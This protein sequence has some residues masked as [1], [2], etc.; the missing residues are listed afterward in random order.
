M[1]TSSRRSRGGVRW[2]EPGRR[3]R[4]RPSLLPVAVLLAVLAAAGAVGYLV[5]ERSNDKAELRET[6]VRFAA[7]WERGDTRAMYREL[8]ADARATYTAR[9]FAADYRTA[10][11][12][13]TAE[14]V[15]VGRIREAADGRV[16]LQVAVRTKLFGTLRGRIALPVT[17]VGE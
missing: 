16:P 3:R 7:A 6:A 17:R 15:A 11:R 4:R 14:K 13:A 5:H 2:L 8:D 9:R 10:G 12:E 1:F